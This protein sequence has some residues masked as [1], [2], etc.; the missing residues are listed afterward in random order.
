MA[1]LLER[2]SL[3]LTPTAYNNGEALCIKPDDG[4]GD[5]QFSRN[6]DATRVNAQGIDETIGIN[7]PRIN[8][9]NGCGHYLW[10]PQSTNL[11]VN[12]ELNN[13]ENIVVSA[14][15]HTISFYGTGSITL[16][17]AHA[18]TL[19]GTGTNER[20]SLTFTPSAG[21]LICTDSGSV[22]KKQI[23]ALS[24]ATSYIP[25]SGSTVTRNQDLCTNASIPSLSGSHTVYADYK[26]YSF[27]SG[28][29]NRDWQDGSNIVYLIYNYGGGLDV[30]NGSTF[31]VDRSTLIPATNFK[32][33]IVTTPT[34]VK[35]FINGVNRTKNNALP[36]LLPITK[37]SSAASPARKISQGLNSLV[38]FNEALS[39]QE[40]TELTTI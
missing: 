23:E 18:A 17:G 7:L 1:N 28:G 32:I 34:T 25:T 37:W 21:T 15:S 3:V 24:Y 16:S 26:N 8:Y 12:S 39:D 11:I 10:E 13:V 31:I 33:A 6:S 29:T 36:N 2:S 38:F 14:V 22:E 19:S 20:V 4:S 35:V 40:L 5:F 9:E 30:Y 27:I